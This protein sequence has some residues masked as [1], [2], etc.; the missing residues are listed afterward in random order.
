MNPTQPSEFYKPTETTIELVGP[1]KCTGDHQ[2]SGN[3]NHEI[4]VAYFQTNPKT[5]LYLN[6][7]NFTMVYGTYNYS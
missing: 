2:P 7:N 5:E 1:Q 6:T 3:L 4:G